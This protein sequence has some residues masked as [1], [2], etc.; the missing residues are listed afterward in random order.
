M[1]AHEWIVE[2]HDRIEL[3][4]GQCDK[5]GAELLNLSNGH[6]HQ[7]DL[8]PGRD[9]LEVSETYAVHRYIRIP[10]HADSLGGRYGFL[11]QLKALGRQLGRHIGKTSDVATRAPKRLDQ[12]NALG[13]SNSAMTIGIVCVARC[14]AS[15]AT[16][17]STTMRSG[18]PRIAA[19]TAASTPV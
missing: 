14:A 2:G 18:L 17:L 9:R 15:A 13:V 1:V 19:S 8:N 16:V 3:R 5:G 11:E 6:G 4:L 12:P 10:K 7:L